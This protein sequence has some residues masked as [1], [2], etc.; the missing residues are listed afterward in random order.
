[1]IPSLKFA[2]LKMKLPFITSVVYLMLT[3]P[4]VF[5]VMQ[6]SFDYRTLEG[7]LF[8]VLVM[9]AAITGRLAGLVSIFLF[10][11][12]TSYQHALVAFTIAW[13][14][15]LLVSFFIGFFIDIYRMPAYHPSQKSE[16]C[17][18]SSTHES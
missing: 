10:E 11:N 16:S 1:M 13:L 4:Y 17:Q 8:I 2:R 7:F 14:V 3:T 6:P 5:N 15:L 9:P 12:P 18:D